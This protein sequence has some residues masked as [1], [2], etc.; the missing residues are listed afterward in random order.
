MPQKAQQFNEHLKKLDFRFET[1]C[2]DLP[3][4]MVGD[5]NSEFD[6]NSIEAL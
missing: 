4:S 2:L 3:K 6:K 5:E 1:Q